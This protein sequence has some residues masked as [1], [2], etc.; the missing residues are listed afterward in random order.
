MIQLISHV[1][2]ALT[3]T[4]LAEDK[5]HIGDFLPQEELKK[6]FETYNVSL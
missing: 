6:F 4:E 3:L 2:W 1:E 5:H